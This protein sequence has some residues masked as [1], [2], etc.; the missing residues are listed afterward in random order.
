MITTTHG[1]LRTK[2]RTGFNEKAS[3]RLIKNAAI[4]APAGETLS[5]RD[6]DYLLRKEV[7]GHRAIVYNAHCYIMSYDN[8]IITMFPVPKWFGKKE[9]YDRKHKVRDPKKYVRYNDCSI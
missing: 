7:G 6:R 4:R 9:Y 2:E 1:L 3:I 8:Y 5:K